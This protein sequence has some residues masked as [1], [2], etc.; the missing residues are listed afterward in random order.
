MNKQFGL[1]ASAINRYCY[2][3]RFDG[4]I[5]VSQFVFGDGLITK[6]MY[7]DSCVVD[8]PDMKCVD[9]QMTK[10]SSSNSDSSSFAFA[11]DNDDGF[12]GREL[13]FNVTF[14]MSATSSSNERMNFDE[15]LIKTVGGDRFSQQ[16][17]QRYETFANV[18]PI[19][20]N[21]LSAHARGQISLVLGPLVARGCSASNL[22]KWM[23]EFNGSM[24]PSINFTGPQ[25]R[26]VANFSDR[27]PRTIIPYLRLDRD[28]TIGGEVLEKLKSAL[29]LITT[30]YALL[31]TL[32]AVGLVGSIALGVRIWRRENKT[33]P[34]QHQ[35]QVNEKE[36]LL[37]SSE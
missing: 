36:A 21:T 23:L 3:Q 15:Y 26:D 35:R 5:N 16:F 9:E 28:A 20:G 10:S 13:P 11:G 12:T 8:S 19:S 14:S 25:Y 24:F 34:Q 29:S 7:L 18:V 4:L 27:M 17:R 22:T 32:L 6:A 2:Q 30:A 33:Q 31:W 1:Q 37:S